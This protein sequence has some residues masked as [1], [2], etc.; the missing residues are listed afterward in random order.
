MSEHQGMLGAISESAEIHR[1]EGVPLAEAYRIQER[2]A[3]K[4]VMAY[5]RER[6]A[7]SSLEAIPLIMAEQNC[8]RKTAQGFWRISQEMKAEASSRSAQIIQ[9]PSRLRG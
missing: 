6:R 5:K 1:D 4:R 3:K 2:R 9:L 7:A 8:D